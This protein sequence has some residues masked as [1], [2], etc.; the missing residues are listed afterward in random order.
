MFIFLH[1][2]TFFFQSIGIFYYTPSL[3]APSTSIMLSERI[4]KYKVQSIFFF[5]MKN[6]IKHTSFLQR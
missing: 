5:Q 3:N 2:F 6:K 1:L 4:L